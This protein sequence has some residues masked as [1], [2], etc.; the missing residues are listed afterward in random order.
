M[1]GVLWAF[2]LSLETH[3]ISLAA[4][5]RQNTCK[6]PH[7]F[8]GDTSEKALFI[9]VSFHF[10]FPGS[11]MIQGRREGYSYEAM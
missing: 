11:R 10:Y 2:G 7:L 4:A 5:S 3:T 1:R 8:P 9:S 6:E